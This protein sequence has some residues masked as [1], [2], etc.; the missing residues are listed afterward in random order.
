MG[1]IDEALRRA[2]RTRRDPD[3]P[4]STD[5]PFVSPWSPADGEF[6]AERIATIAPAPAPPRQAMPWGSDRSWAPVQGFAAGWR[7]RLV[8]G[9]DSNALLADQ[10][11][12]MAATLLHLQRGEK[13]R[14]V[15]V[16]SALAAD[17]K[18]M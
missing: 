14:T 12:R 17:G 1:R 15:M 18:T 5:G 9:R 8:I 2:G 6:R 7:E 16:T 11:R 13:L 3:L 4:R 10:F